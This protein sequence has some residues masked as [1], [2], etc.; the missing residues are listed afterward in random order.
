MQ[1]DYRYVCKGITGIH[2]FGF[3]L[4]IRVDQ[5]DMVITADDVPQSR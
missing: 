2:F 5:R 4:E 3:P 1:E